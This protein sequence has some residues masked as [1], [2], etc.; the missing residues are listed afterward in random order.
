V[1]VLLV[2]LE[3]VGEVVDAGGEQGHLDFR[4]AGV[5]GDALELFDDLGGIDGHG[6]FFSV[7]RSLQE[8]RQD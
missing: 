7:M 1:V 6:V 3:V 4:G 5:V 8:R 2:G